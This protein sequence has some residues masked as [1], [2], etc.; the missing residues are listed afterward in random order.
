M[1]YSSLTNDEL[2]RCLEESDSELCQEAAKRL[3]S[4]NPVQE[5]PSSDLK[6]RFKDSR[7]VIQSL[8]AC[9]D[10]SDSEAKDLEG[11]VDDFIKECEE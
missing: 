6:D 4:Y 11:A 7:N 10:D 2:I 1:L 5:K 8:R 3:L 9:I